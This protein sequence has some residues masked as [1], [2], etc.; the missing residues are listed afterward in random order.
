MPSYCKNKLPCLL[1]TYFPT[2]S[3]A[4]NNVWPSPTVT[5][6]STGTKG[7]RSW[8]RQTPLKQCGSLRR[9]HFCSKKFSADG[10]LNRSQSY[11][12]SSRFPQRWQATRA[13]S[14]AYVA[15]HNGEIHC[16]K[17]ASPP[18]LV[19]DVGTYRTHDWIFAPIIICAELFLIG[20]RV[21]NGWPYPTM[22]PGSHQRF[23]NPHNN[24]G[25]FWT[26]EPHRE[27]VF[28]SIARLIETISIPA[29]CTLRKWGG[30]KFHA[31][32]APPNDIFVGFLTPGPR[33]SRI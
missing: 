11:W 20:S 31:H 33:P 19:F 12:I 24:M 21:A 7:N 32:Q 16:W 15:A 10:T 8:K 2:P 9:V 5:Q 4:C 13:S 26:L 6:S 29:A 3:E 28:Q 30:S 25:L 23:H 22:R 17:T 27:S 18:P 14:T 1:P